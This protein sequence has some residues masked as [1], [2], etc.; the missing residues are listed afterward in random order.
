MVRTDM[1]RPTGVTILGVLAII[2]NAGAIAL[3]LIFMLGSDFITHRLLGLPAVA[4][5]G[6]AVF[7]GIGLLFLL[8]GAVGLV[9][10]ISLLNLANWARIVTMVFAVIGVAA[11]ALE[12]LAPSLMSCQC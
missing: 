12:C 3:G 10:A 2:G 8:S 11:A 1:V 5:A 7:V 9:I 6:V 4:V